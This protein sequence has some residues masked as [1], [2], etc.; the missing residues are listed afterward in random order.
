[1]HLH[2][3]LAV[4]LFVI[5]RFLWLIEVVQKLLGSDRSMIVITIYLE[6]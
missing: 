6:N 4:G 5:L 2:E 3:N 1:M